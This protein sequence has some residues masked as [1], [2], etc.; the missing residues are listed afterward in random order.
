VSNPWS[1]TPQGVLLRVHL[2]PRAA[3]N[4]LVGLH[5]EALK[6]ALTAPPVDGAANV[7]LLIFV[8]DLLRL[9]RSAVS[10]ASGAKSREKRLLISTE[11][12]PRI[13]QRLKSLVTPVDKPRGDD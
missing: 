1:L 2:Q 7:A 12:P 9:P 3:H 4:R 13:I 11:D 6:V 5:G 8:A 10:L